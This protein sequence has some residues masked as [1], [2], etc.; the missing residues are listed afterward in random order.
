MDSNTAT[1]ARVDRPEEEPQL[2][3]IDR[4]RR[5]SDEIGSE[6]WPAGGQRRETS[7]SG[8]AARSTT[9]QQG[10]VPVSTDDHAGEPTIKDSGTTT[11]DFDPESE[12]GAA[13]YHSQGVTNHPPDSETEIYPQ[14]VYY[15]PMI[16]SNILTG[17]IL[18]QSAQGA[19]YFPQTSQTLWPE[20]GA[21]YRPIKASPVTS[22]LLP[23]AGRLLR[24]CLGRLRVKTLT[25]RGAN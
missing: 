7:S 8:A 11:T 20:H 9:I 2:V 19:F 10:E 17:N 16:D 21:H 13:L 22:P 25:M 6:F 24:L 5:C 4:L 18:L 14:Q 1:I 3:A 12:D 15:K 23:H